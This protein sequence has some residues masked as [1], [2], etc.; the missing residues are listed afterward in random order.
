MSEV[1][2][3]GTQSVGRALAV[4]KLLAG[5]PD[6]LSGN[7]IANSLRLSSG[8]ANRLIRALI[9][10]GLVARNPVSDCYYL[11]S[12]AVLLGQAA[13]RGFGI[14]KALPI[15]ERLNRETEEAIN[16]SIRQ[17]TESVVMM[18]VPCTLPLRFEQH[19]GARF[20]LYSTA[21][22][23]AIL[24]FSPDA[25]QYLNSLPAKLRKVT[26]HSLSTPAALADQ[27][28][29]VRRRGYSIDEQENIEGLRCVGAPVLDPEG[30]AQAALVIQ[31]PTVRMSRNRMRTLGKQVAQ[32]A[33]DVS[34]FVP[35]N[36]AMSF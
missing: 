25:D 35:V 1:L 16:L 9:A 6:E 27:L 32:A 28:A 2:P 31:A 17:G 14:D 20:P 26:P 22:G 5:S 18:R 8:T 10:E 4:L 24:A 21:S 23:K 12:G 11:G 13:Q 15:L 3:A 33:R 7:A 36:R 30:N 34:Q 19:T 29:G